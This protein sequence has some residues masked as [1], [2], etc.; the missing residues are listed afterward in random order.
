MQLIRGPPNPTPDPGEKK[1]LK[2]FVELT[3]Q[4]KAVESVVQVGDSSTQII[5]S[6]S[7][8]KYFIPT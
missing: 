4:I 6:K 5:K 3:G 2:E 1:G 8:Q 7:N